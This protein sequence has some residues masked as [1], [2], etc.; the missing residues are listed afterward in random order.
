MAKTLVNIISAQTIPNY[1]FIKDFYLE[2]DSLLFF[3]SS[4]ITKPLENILDTLG[5]SAKDVEIQQL[6]EENWQIMCQEIASVIKPDVN[7]LVNTTG[8]T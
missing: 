5:I 8:G 7:Y 3:T 6:T 2:G 4:T 1:I